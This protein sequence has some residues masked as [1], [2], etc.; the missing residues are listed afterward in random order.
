MIRKGQAGVGFCDSNA[1]AAV[2][3]QD[4]RG[5][6]NPARQGKGARRR[7]RALQDPNLFPAL[8]FPA[9]G[10][11][12][13]VRSRRHALHGSAP[14]TANLPHTRLRFQKT[15]PGGV[16]WSGRFRRRPRPIL[17]QRRCLM[18]PPASP[19]PAA[20]GPRLRFAPLRGPCAR[21]EALGARDAIASHQDLTRTK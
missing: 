18:Q 2:Q 6:A 19:P 9:A 16:H 12:L 10:L 15:C 4:P 17:L 1:A 5:K 3:A 14:R 21:G 8:L 11:G 20:Q 13:G 7:D